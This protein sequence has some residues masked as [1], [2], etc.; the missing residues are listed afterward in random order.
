MAKRKR[1]T[2]APSAPIAP[3]ASSGP[4]EAKAWKGGWHGSRTRPA[5]IAD[6]AGAA[7][8]QAALEEIA[9]EMTAARSE[10]RLVQRIALDAIDESHLVRDRIHVDNTEMNA[11]VASLRSRGQQTPM[12]VVSLGK[13]RFGLISGWRRLVALKRLRDD[14]GGATDA[15]CLVRATETSTEAYVAMVE[16]NEIRAGLSFYERARIAMRAAEQGAY[17]SGRLAVKGLFA[18]APAPKRS[19]IVAFI[20]I[21]EALDCI[22]KFPSAISER[23]GLALA[24]H[25]DSDT[26]AAAKLRAALVQARAQTPEVEQAILS[27]ALAPHA[28]EAPAPIPVQKVARCAPQPSAPPEEEPG[29][30]MMHVKG[31]I[32]LRGVGVDQ[33]LVADLEA[34]LAARMNAL[35]S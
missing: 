8:T 16:E 18:N 27:A 22:L 4:L 24:K 7:A 6:V 5:P 13:G 10:G 32:T 34:W 19:K 15:L 29:V 21:Y 26:E 31:K 12:E 3:D 30:T 23:M 20:S 9:G 1:L 35:N 28:S 2:P 11:L 14:E 25:L 17:P 33:A